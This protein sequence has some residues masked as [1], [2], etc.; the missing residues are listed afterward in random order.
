METNIRQ[1]ENTDEM[2]PLLIFYEHNPAK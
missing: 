2:I 1:V